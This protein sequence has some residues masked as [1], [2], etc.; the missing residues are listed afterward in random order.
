MVSYNVTFAEIQNLVK[1]NDKQR[2]SLIP[3]PNPSPAASGHSSSTE[4]SRYLIRATQGHTL[5]VSNEKLL[6]PILTTDTD[7]PDLVVHGTY[8]PEWHKIR[9]S[10]GLK[11][12]S[13]RHI[14]FATGLPEKLPP[15]SSDSQGQA[16]VR[17]E[18]EGDVVKSGMR[19]SAVIFI[20][21]DVKMSMEGG[22]KW[23]R[24][25]NGVILTEGRNG[26]LDLDWAAL[27]ERR[28]TEEVL[29]GSRARKEAVEHRN[30]GREIETK[31]RELRTE[32]A[33]SKSRGEEIR[34]PSSVKD[35]WD[36]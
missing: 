13:R 2:F 32:E 20:W 33:T 17:D 21:V 26:L 4:P 30:S 7:C 35:N 5:V 22:V 19:K 6:Q 12:M 29:W 36:D 16:K 24:S 8:F 18:G 10:G 28:G 14:H 25:E 11:P 34:E 15:L 31:M 1:T 27:V 23:W 3:N 9:E